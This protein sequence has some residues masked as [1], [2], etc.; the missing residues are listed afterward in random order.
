MEIQK[1]FTCRWKN[2]EYFTYAVS[3][4]YIEVFVIWKIENCF[5][6]VRSVFVEIV[7]LAYLVEEVTNE[8]PGVTDGRILLGDGKFI[9]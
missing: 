5:F 1:H 6:F 3:P 7:P 2:Y 9:G 4:E 8:V